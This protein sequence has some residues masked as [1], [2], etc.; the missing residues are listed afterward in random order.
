MSNWSSDNIW[1]NGSLVT[2][3]ALF[4]KNGSDDTNTT[5]RI[6]IKRRRTGVGHFYV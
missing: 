5:D 3:V 6:V 1:Q 4:E 2:W